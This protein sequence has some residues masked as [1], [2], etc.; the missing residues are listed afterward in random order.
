V[1]E[2]SIWRIS[3]VVVIDI[4]IQR[5]SAVPVAVIEIFIWRISA[6]PVAV[7]EI[8]NDCT[9][10]IGHVIIYLFFIIIYHL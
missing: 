3:A 4:F 8:S 2:I 6:V 7:I 5:I 10:I 9:P 1:I